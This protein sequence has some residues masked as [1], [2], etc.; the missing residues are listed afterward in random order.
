MFRCKCLP[1]NID[2]ELQFCNVKS[3]SDVLSVSQKLHLMWTKSTLVTN[4]HGH[5]HKVPQSNQTT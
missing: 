5:Q 4:G 3:C 1:R 2:I